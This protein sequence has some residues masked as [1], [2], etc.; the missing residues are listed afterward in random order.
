MFLVIFLSVALRWVTGGTRHLFKGK[1]NGLPHFLLEFFNMM[2]M[3]TGV[4]T[5]EVL[6]IWS[7]TDTQTSTA[8]HLG[9]EVV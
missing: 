5:R 7:L 8:Y 3:S 1:Q 6:D 4:L 2:L 9:S